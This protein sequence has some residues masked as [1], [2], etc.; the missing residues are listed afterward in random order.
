ME[1][2]KLDRAHTF[3]AHLL[4][5]RSTKDKETFCTISQ[6]ICQR[7]I[8]LYGLWFTGSHVLTQYQS[9]FTYLR[10]DGLSVHK[11]C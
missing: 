8:K 5:V 10:L 6:I 3:A 9:H 7:N 1:R 11:G 2:K 4:R